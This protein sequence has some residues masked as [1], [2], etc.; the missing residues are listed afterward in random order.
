M[1]RMSDVRCRSRMF[2]TANGT[3]R[4]E[5]NVQR[6]TSNLELAEEKLI[7]KPGKQETEFSTET[8]NEGGNRVISEQRS[9]I[10]D[11]WAVNEERTGAYR[12]DC[13]KSS[14]SDSLVISLARQ[15]DGCRC[16]KYVRR[17]MS[18]TGVCLTLREITERILNT[19][20][21]WND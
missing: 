9:V 6:R 21:T 19:S 20:R 5:A 12:A 4:E 15:P 3:G 17:S 11:L 13:R 1:C 14:A 10:G 2:A 18:R 16:T 8:A 7:R